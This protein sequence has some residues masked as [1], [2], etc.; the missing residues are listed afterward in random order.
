MKKTVLMIAFLCFCL[1]AFSQEVVFDAQHFLTVQENQAM[2]MSAEETHQQYLGKVNDNV[3]TVN[4]NV[5]SVVAAQ[6]LIYK[7]LAN[8]NSALKD[9][10][11]VKNITLTT[12]DI[13]YYMDQALQMAKEDPFLLLVAEKIQQSFGP[14]ATAMVG[15]I[16]GFILKSDGNVLADYNGRDQL[17]RKVVQ[18]L[19]IL[20]GMAY[21]AWKTMYWAKERGVLKTINPFAAYINKDAAFATQIIQKIKYLNL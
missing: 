6:T 18:Q 5:S 14:K 16:S 12:T 15:D 2:R 21:G 17:L 7:S 9:G 8:V 11:M 10:L 19:Q 20:D 1:S 13:I 4:T 3:N